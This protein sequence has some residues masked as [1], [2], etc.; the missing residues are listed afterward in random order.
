MGFQ[1]EDKEFLY[2]IIKSG[3]AASYDEPL[4]EVS[5][6]ILNTNIDTTLSR[7]QNLK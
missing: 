5:H 7:H 6:I 2:R 3:G 4:E 1:N